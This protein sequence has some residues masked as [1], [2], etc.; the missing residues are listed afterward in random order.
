MTGTE[1]ESHRPAIRGI[2]HVQIAIPSGNEEQ[3]RT[4]YCTV[5]GLREVEKPESLRGRG[6]FWL[7][8]GNRQVHVGTESSEIHRAATKAHVAYEVADLA[9][10][11][12]YLASNGIAVLD[13]MPIPGCDRFEFRDPFGNR[14]EFIEVH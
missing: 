6:G 13:G 1:R 3:A 14:V 2:H 10:W 12:A 5:L 9:T 11:R 4:F 8:V 7:Q